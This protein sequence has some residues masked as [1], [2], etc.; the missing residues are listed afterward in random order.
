V[1][2]LRGTSTNQVPDAKLSM[3]IAGPMVTNVS[4]LIMGSG[5]TL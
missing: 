3:N 5:D 1:R 2:Q 4:S